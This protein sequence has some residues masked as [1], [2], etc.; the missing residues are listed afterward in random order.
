[1]AARKSSSK[2]GLPDDCDPRVRLDLKFHTGEVSWISDSTGPRSP[3]MHSGT[4]RNES[5]PVA[6]GRRNAPRHRELA[7]P[8]RSG[9]RAPVA[10]RG[11][12][13]WGR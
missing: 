11:T 2:P 12:G 10:T 9:G 1:M 3:I 8:G 13:R 5:P 6:L 7:G 4:S